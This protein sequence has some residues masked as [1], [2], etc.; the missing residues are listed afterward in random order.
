MG[1]SLTTV[2]ISMVSNLD[3]S[4]GKEKITEGAG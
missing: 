4:K 2:V 1:V 3:Y